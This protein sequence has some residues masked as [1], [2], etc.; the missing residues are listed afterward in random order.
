MGRVLLFQVE[1]GL[2]AVDGSEDASESAPGSGSNV[3]TR[4]RRR[5]LL[6]GQKFSLLRTAPEGVI[7][8]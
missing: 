7:I 1:L 4:T 5:P 3:S 6:T 2:Q 8:A